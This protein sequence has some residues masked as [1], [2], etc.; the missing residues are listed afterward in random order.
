MSL[1]GWLIDW[2]ID[3][4]IDWYCCQ[5]VTA[6][7]IIWWTVTTFRPNSRKSVSSCRNDPEWHPK[8]V[9]ATGNGPHTRS[10]EVTQF[11][12]ISY[13]RFHINYGPILHRWRNIMAQN[14]NF[15]TLHLHITHHLRLFPFEFCIADSAEKLEWRGY[16]VTYKLMT[17]TPVST[18]TCQTD[19]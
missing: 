10:S 11:D 14:R 2:L 1:I 5:L 13:Y 3:W 18:L 12:K 8:V 16:Q 4:S 15:S 9:L 19:G 7:L 6:N 17:C